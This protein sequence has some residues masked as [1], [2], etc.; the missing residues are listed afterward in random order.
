M[1]P[2]RPFLLDIFWHSGLL[3]LCV[4]SLLLPLTLKNHIITQ[5]A[6]LLIWGLAANKGFCATALRNQEH[7]SSIIKHGWALVP[8]MARDLLATISYPLQADSN[9]SGSSQQQCLELLWYLQL[10]VCVVGTSLVCYRL[11]LGRR[12]RFLSGALA[13]EPARAAAAEELCLQGWSQIH[14]VGALLVVAWLLVDMLVWIQNPAGITA[15]AAA[16]AAAV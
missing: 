8:S 11:E 4:Y 13:D 9:P 10:C 1:L 16:A 7:I 2:R 15:A 5:A 3:G 6:Q 14:Y 12:R